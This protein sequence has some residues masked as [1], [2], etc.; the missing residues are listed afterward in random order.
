MKSLKELP[1]DEYIKLC[2]DSGDYLIDTENGEIISLKGRTPRK[3]KYDNC[4]GYDIVNLSIKGTTR[5]ARVHR[6]IMLKAYNKI[7]NDKVVDHLNNDKHDNRLINLQFLTSRENYQKAIKDGLVGKLT[8]SQKDDIVKKY[9]N[10]NIS[11]RKLAKEYGVVQG[12][13]QNVLRCN[14]GNA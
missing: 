12:S 5:R 1:L 11:Q 7:D 6:V 10:G 14:Y 4:C 8:Y 13:I 9:N 2:I 3:L